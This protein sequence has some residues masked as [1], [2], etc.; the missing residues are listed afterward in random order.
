MLLSVS[1]NFT[2]ACM[3]GGGNESPIF[4]LLGLES[5]S[6]LHLLVWEG[7]KISLLF[8]AFGP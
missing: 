6:I 2:F 4:E 1:L 5:V 8:W 7:E 3:G